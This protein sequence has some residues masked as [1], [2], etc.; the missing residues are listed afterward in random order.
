VTDEQQGDRARDISHGDL[1]EIAANSIT[2]LDEAVRTLDC[3][4]VTGHTEV[5]YMPD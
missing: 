1:R 5:I 3:C 2:G 4:Q